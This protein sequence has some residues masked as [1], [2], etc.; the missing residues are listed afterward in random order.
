MS[1]KTIVERILARFVSR[2]AHAGE[3][4]GE[5]AAPSFVTLCGD[6]DAVRRRDRGHIEV[7]A[8]LLAKG[9]HGVGFGGAARVALTML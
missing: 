3:G 7:A 2:V 5:G 6:G 4:V 8:P 9:D 1:G